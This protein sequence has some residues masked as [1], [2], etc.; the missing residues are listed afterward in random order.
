MILHAITRPSGSRFDG[1]SAGGKTS[2]K[3]FNFGRG[4]VLL[5]MAR[6]VPSLPVLAARS[7]PCS[8]QGQGP[9]KWSLPGSSTRTTSERTAAIG[10]A[11]ETM[12]RPCDPREVL[13]GCQSTRWETTGMPM[14]SQTSRPPLLARR[15]ALETTLCRCSRRR[16]R[17][18]RRNGVP[19][20]RTQVPV[21]GAFI[22]APL[23]DIDLATRMATLK[24][25][26]ADRGGLQRR[27]CP[28]R[29]PA[30]RGGER[31]ELLQCH[32]H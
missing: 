32:H 3:P 9:W 28:Y 22:R 10:R 14:P 31:N 25:P 6:S 20:G 23:E 4:D 21:P 15:H 5:A 30:L 13:A 24:S 26:I 17:W 29:S 1:V 12:R 11:G 16:P 2:M 18:I 8:R 7:R 19:C 27:L